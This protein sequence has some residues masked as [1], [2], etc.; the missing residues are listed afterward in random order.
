M[1]LNFKRW[2]LGLA[3][4][5]GP[6]YLALRMRRQRKKPVLVSLY[7]GLFGL[8]NIK[9]RVGRPVI[10]TWAWEAASESYCKGYIQA[11]SFTVLVDGE[12]VDVAER[13]WVEKVGNTWAVRW[14]STPVV[15][16]GGEHELVLVVNLKQA[17]SDGFDSN[18]DGQIDMYGPGEERQPPCRLVAR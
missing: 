11:A 15:F 4:V 9:V 18:S 1:K 2:A 8:K 5:G 12:P 17:V 16:G 13:L 14:R 3:A 6:A 7:S 10:L